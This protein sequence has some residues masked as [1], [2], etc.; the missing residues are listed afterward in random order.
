MSYEEEELMLLDMICES[1]DEVRTTLY[2]TYEPVIKG[3]I[4]KY[5]RSAQKLGIDLNDLIQEANVGFA[6]ALNK[7]DSSKDAS[8][9]TFIGLCVDRRLLNYIY[10]NKT[11]KSQMAQESLSLDY[12]Y[13][14]NGLPLRDV[15]KDD[16]A[17]PFKKIFNETSYHNAIEKMSDRLSLQEKEVFTYLTNGLDYIEIAK[18]LDKSPKQIDNTIQRI[19]AKIKDA[20]KEEDYE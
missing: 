16:E 5:V 2:K 17:D 4:K 10:K 18:R 3:V 20:L 13:D 11:I 9:K 7:Y 1:N 15:L 12:D 19:R 8:L 6:N 14:E